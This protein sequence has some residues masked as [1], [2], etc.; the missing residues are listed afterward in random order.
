MRSFKVIAI[1]L[2][3]C[4]IA[5]LG[6]D[7]DED[8]GPTGPSHGLSAETYLPLKIGATW[9]HV[10]IGTEQGK[11]FTDTTT[12]TI[13][14]KTTISYNKKTYFVMVGS[15]EDS[16]YLRIMNNIVYM[17]V[18]GEFQEVP[19]YNFNKEF[20]QTWEIFTEKS[21]MGSMSGTGKFLG[22]DNITVPAG[23][24]TGCAKFEIT[25]NAIVYNNS[26]QVSRSIE[27]TE[28]IWFAPNVGIAK[29]TE[30]TKENN[31]VILNSTE[32][33]INYFIPE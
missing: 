22:I 17:F 14:R 7:K 2:L 4:F 6:C 23:T 3:V 20:G 16:T 9:T 8:N 30:E 25:W 13:A 26:G 15:D 10:K 33:L 1:F 5:L 11:A 28:V 21:S 32:E 29:S 31:A 18:P 12:E 27:G 19:I 24:F